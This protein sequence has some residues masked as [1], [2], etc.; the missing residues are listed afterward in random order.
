MKAWIWKLLSK[1]RNDLKKKRCYCRSWRLIG[2]KFKN[3]KIDYVDE[4]KML[5]KMHLCDKL[6]YNGWLIACLILVFND[7]Q[8]I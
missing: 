2:Y 1:T 8:Y 7:T 6:E 4:N 5:N 3:I